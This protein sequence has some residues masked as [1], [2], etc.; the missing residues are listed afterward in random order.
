[1]L[2]DGIIAV[3]NGNT[4]VTALVAGRIYKS[5]LPRGYVLPAL[6]IHRYG[7]TQDYSYAGPIRL[8][9]DQ[10]QVDCYADD[11]ETAQ[12]V[13]AAVRSALAGFTGALNDGTVVQGC[14]LE[15]DMDMPF[16]PHADQ[17]GIANRTLLGFRVVSNEAQE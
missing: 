6:A 12:Q 16:M 15:R 17:K 13:A 9:E 3:L 11:A 7:G 8:R 10:I 4:G 14:Y 5:V 2:L 1:M